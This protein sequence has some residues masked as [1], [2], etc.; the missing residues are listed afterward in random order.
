MASSIHKHAAAALDPAPTEQ[1]QFQFISIQAPNDA[2]DKTQRRRARSHAVKQALEKKRKQQQKSQ[3]N[4]RVTTSTTT[5]TTSSALK[6]KDDGETQTQAHAQALFSPSAGKLDPFHSFAVDLT[7][8]QILLGDYRA[9]VAPEPVFTITEELAFQNFHSVFRT[10]FDDPALLNAVML[11]LAFAVTGGKVD[12]ECLR[13][14]SQ[15]I[16]YIRERIAE[17]RE[18]TSEATIGSILLLAGVEARLGMM[19]QVQ[20][21]M[22]AVQQLL[23]MCQ[24][25]GIFL[26]GGIKRAIFWQDLNSSI[27]AGT[28]RVYSHTTFSELQWIRDPFVPNFFRLPPGFST[29][30]SLFT[31]E[32]IEVLEDLHA[33]Q[34]IREVP[35]YSKADI[36]LMMHVNNHTAS[37]QSR[38]VGLPRSGIVQECCHLAAYHCSVMLCC[39]IWCALVIPSHISA[40]LLHKLQ[41]SSDDVIWDDH[42]ELLLWLLYV[43]GAFTSPGSVRSEYIALIR[44]NNG[45]RSRGL[46]E[47]WPELRE[48]LEQF[49]W[50]EKAFLRAVKGLYM[51]V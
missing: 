28:N 14:Q 45:T 34:C 12:G 37:I 49:I 32:F 31:P 10:G 18:V 51:E 16:R 5:T 39:H 48:L 13:Y 38:L 8:L 7:R 43:G 23:K 36:M 27:L 41:Q 19:A 21:H 44:L 35:Y 42:P 22:G 9:R 46:Y 26:T 6:K 20:M 50:S 4:F 15:A 3:Q 11:S 17:V 40:Q 1:I 47:M 33:L 24:A 2:N 29:R 30:S 25:K